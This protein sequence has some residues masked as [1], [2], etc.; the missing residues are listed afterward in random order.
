[1]EFRLMQVIN[2]MIPLLPY[3]MEILM[4]ELELKE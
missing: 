1:M 4:V 2:L 3:I